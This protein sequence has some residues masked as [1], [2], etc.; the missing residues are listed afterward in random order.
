MI[1]IQPDLGT[2]KHLTYLRVKHYYWEFKDWISLV[3]EFAFNVV[4]V[5]K[6]LSSPLCLRTDFEDLLDP[7][8]GCL[9]QAHLPPA[10]TLN[11]QCIPMPGL[12]LSLDGVV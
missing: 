11:P 5:L 6:T 9:L 7:A 2:V 3:E 1:E 8:P 12:L 10:P 4:A